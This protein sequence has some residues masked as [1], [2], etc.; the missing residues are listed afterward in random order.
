MLS[1]EPDDLPDEIMSAPLGSFLLPHKPIFVRRD[2]W[3]GW[4]AFRLHRTIIYM[5]GPCYA[6]KFPNWNLERGLVITRTELAAG[7]AL[8]LW[9]G[10]F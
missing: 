10:A 5:I 1:G 2:R 9:L 6:M 4:P 7:A 3:T 8:L